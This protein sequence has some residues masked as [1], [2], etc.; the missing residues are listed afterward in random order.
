MHPETIR[1]FRR[2]LSLARGM[3]KAFEDYLGKMERLQAPGMR[4]IAPP[5]VT[6][7]EPGE[8]EA[9]SAKRARTLQR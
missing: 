5:E 6:M 8:S 3:L 4:L 2:L 7:D 9:R 1:L